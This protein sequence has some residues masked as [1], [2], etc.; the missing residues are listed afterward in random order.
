MSPDTAFVKEW[1]RIDG[2]EF[3]LVLPTLISTATALAS[4]ETGI[5]YLTAVM[6]A[7]I[8]AWCAAQVAYWIANPEA[9][10]EKRIMPSPFHAGLL[11]PYR[12]Y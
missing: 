9:G 6:P 1:C 5:D 7:P 4:H 8:Q 12:T 2:T 11:D 10:Y 3:D